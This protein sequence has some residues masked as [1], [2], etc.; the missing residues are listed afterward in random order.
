MV[1]VA[2]HLKNGAK[3][4]QTVEAPRGSETSFA[5]EADIV[6]KFKKLATPYSRRRQS[7]RHSSIS[8]S[9][10]KSLRGPSRLPRLWPTA[11]GYFSLVTLILAARSLR[12]WRSVLVKLTKSATEPPAGSMPVGIN[13]FRTS[14]VFSAACSSAFIR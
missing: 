7:G 11:D 12:R 13:L 6:Q 5:S 2:V 14:S 3:L 1:R 9:A 8:C 10:P 4:E